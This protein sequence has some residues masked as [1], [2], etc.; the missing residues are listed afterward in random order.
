MNQIYYNELS[1]I[2][3]LTRE[4]Q[5][6]LVSKAKA[7]DNTSRERLI[8]SHLK[9]V[10]H[11]AKQMEK[12][13]TPDGTLTID[14]LIGEGN[15][16]LIDAI[17]GYKPDSGTTLSYFAGVVV[18]RRITSFIL[19]NSSAIRTPERKM[20]ALLKLAKEQESV[21]LDESA[22]E[23]QIP[24]KVIFPDFIETITDEN[25][26]EDISEMLD[27][28]QAALKLLKPREK[29]IIEYYFGINEKV[30]K[31][32][33]QIASDIG[34]TKSRVNQIITSTID[35]IRVNPTLSN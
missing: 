33:V 24:S 25:D 14:D 28:I 29:E 17:K 13:L 26:N 4:E 27:K 19:Q 15:I 2:P 21:G 11:Y 7:G 3:S 10:V 18:K 1:I 23:I 12:F 9:L 35:K 16:A 32:Q 31:S 6:D 20:K 5:L 34:I 22:G 30:K 8:N